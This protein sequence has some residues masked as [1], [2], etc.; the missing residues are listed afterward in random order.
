MASIYSRRKEISLLAVS[1]VLAFC[2][3]GYQFLISK[4]LIMQT[5]K[6]IFSLSLT[7][8]FFILGL[9]LAARRY[10]KSQTANADPV[11]TLYFV[12]WGLSI[13]GGLTPILLLLGYCYYKS[14]IVHIQFL[15]NPNQ[16]IFLMIVLFQVF[17][18]GIGFISGFEIP[19]MNQIL[20]EE[21][22][23]Q[24]FFHVLGLTSLGG[25]TAAIVL[26]WIMIPHFDLLVS[27]LILGCLNYAACVW[28]FFKRGFAA[29]VRNTVVLVLPLC[30]FIFASAE[31][32][33]VYQLFLK[34]YYTRIPSK[35]LSPKMN[36]GYWDAVLA[37]SPIERIRTLYQ[38]VDIV[39]DQLVV[40]TP[41]KT[42]ELRNVRYVALDGQVQFGEE[43]EFVYHDLM[44]HVVF[45]TGKP[46]PDR[47]LI[48]GAGDGLLARELLR[49]PEVKS[50]DLVELDPM[51]IELANTH[52]FFTNLNKL[53]LK[54]ER[55][56]VH[57]GDAAKYLLE[58]PQPYSQIY[59][60]FPFPNTDEI[61]KLYSLEFYDL[62]KTCLTD[63]GSIV[64]DFPVRISEPFTFDNPTSIFMKTL[65]AAGYKTIWPY[66]RDPFPFMLVE[67][68]E[69]KIEFKPNEHIRPRSMEY[70]Y[71]F[72]SDKF[73]SDPEVP[74]NSLF[75]PQLLGLP[76]QERIFTS[77]PV[78]R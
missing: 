60:D 38:Y 36:S 54:N 18:L 25:L 30:V 16:Y 22:S 77:T 70:Y 62:V 19:L 55:V 9:G 65:K 49:Y 45:S 75:K 52:P 32:E 7:T 53:S 26:N 72:S 8:G 78:N 37:H 2:S 58:C 66:G 68:N 71:Q 34:S 50:I 42:F 6:A 76:L 13:I 12:E 51:M 28:L 31:Q 5:Q 11:G 56:H 73:H 74:I 67:K 35:Q 41:E 57:V 15:A 63:D 44:A 69:R 4:T 33:Y 23:K 21:L 29:T 47:V 24:K 27:G 39:Q 48:L 14:P 64:L 3:F 1:F 40:Q 61:S 17:S 46:V 43:E 59:I 20:K 10:R